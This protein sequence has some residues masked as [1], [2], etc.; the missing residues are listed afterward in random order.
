MALARPRRY[1]E[2]GNESPRPR[3]LRVTRSVV[4]LAAL[5]LMTMPPILLDG[6][7]TPAG[8]VFTGYVVIARDAEVYQALW[9]AGWQGAWL[10]HSPC[11]SGAL[12][13][14]ELYPWSVWRAHQG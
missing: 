4:F 12:A 1:E 5:C 2:P 6:I 7:R 14:I 11:R 9:R 13:G 8:S 3:R 10:F